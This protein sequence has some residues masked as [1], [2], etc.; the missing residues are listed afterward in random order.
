MYCFFVAGVYMGGIT[1]GIPMILMPSVIFLPHFP[2]L[3]V[4]LCFSVSLLASLSQSGLCSIS[5]VASYAHPAAPSHISGVMSGVVIKIGI[6]GILR[7][8]LLI[9]TDYTLLGFSSYS[10]FPIVSGVYGVMLAI[11]QHNLKKLLA[12]HSIENIG[13][14]GIGIDWAQLELGPIISF[15]QRWDSRA[16]VLHVLKSTHSLSRFCFTGQEMFTGNSSQ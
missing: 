9:K 15:S 11:V 13:I 16:G 6:Y 1:H 5:Y 3:P 10:L 4:W 8:L 2:H 7:M 12:Y 14:I